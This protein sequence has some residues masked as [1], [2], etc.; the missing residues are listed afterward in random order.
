MFRA[1]EYIELGRLLLSEVQP[2]SD[3][4]SKAWLNR[5]GEWVNANKGDPRARLLNRWHRMDGGTRI[6]WILAWAR[7]GFQRV[8][9]GHKLAASLMATYAGDDPDVMTCAPWDAY[10]IE[11]PPELIPL[12]AGGQSGSLDVVSVWR[13]PFDRK[14]FFVISSRNSDLLVSGRLAFPLPSFDLDR[15]NVVLSDDQQSSVVRARECIARLIVGTELEMTDPSRVKSPG[16]STKRARADGAA[17]SGVHRLL[18]EV[19]VDC[20]AAIAGY[21]AGTRRNSPSVQTLVRGHF[22]RVAHGAGR[23]E[24]RWTHIEPYWRGPEDAPVAVRPH[25]MPDRG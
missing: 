20:R 8:L 19:K 13:H 15:A 10:T 12:T 17:P 21:I 2:R 18:R 1:D 16:S 9:V 24:R 14:S 6:C 4:P 3:E 11:M 23:T 5:V 22:K 25:M 7:C